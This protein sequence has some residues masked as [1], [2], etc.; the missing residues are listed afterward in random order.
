MERSARRHNTERQTAL[1][2]KKIPGAVH[3]GDA[4]FH[5]C[6]LAPEPRRADILSHGLVFWLPVRPN[7]RPSH[8]AERGSGCRGFRPRLQRRVRNGFTPFS[9]HSFTG[10]AYPWFFSW[11]PIYMELPSASLTVKR[12]ARSRKASAQRGGSPFTDSRRGL[13]SGT[14]N[15]RTRIVPP[16]CQSGWSL[17]WKSI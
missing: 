4:V 3:P 8:L 2:N 13:P 15:L 5:P 10:R 11:S 7:R 14:Y 12:K 1:Q 9:L 17:S 16:A 6:C